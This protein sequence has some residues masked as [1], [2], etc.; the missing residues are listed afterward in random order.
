MIGQLKRKVSEIKF[1]NKLKIALQ[2]ESDECL[3]WTLEEVKKE[4]ERRNRHVKK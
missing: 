3:K 4:I 1:R 2:S